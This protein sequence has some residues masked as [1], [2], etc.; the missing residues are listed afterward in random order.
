MNKMCVI[1]STS[2]LL[3]FKTLKRLLIA[4]WSSMCKLRFNICRMIEHLGLSP[5]MGRFSRFSK[6]NRGK[7]Y[8]FYVLDVDIRWELFA[9]LLFLLVHNAN[10]T[11]ITRTLGRLVLL[12]WDV[13]VCHYANAA[14]CWRYSSILS[15]LLYHCYL[16]WIT[17]EQTRYSATL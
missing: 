16:Y 2:P 6:R 1:S 17:C 11:G 10:S 14:Q 4:I 12:T 8:R 13:Y 3:L 15:F 7:I 5:L 9:E